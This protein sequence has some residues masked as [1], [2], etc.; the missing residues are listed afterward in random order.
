M[1]IAGKEIYANDDR[2][3]HCM[4]YSK[5]LN[6]HCFQTYTAD[7]KK[8]FTAEQRAK[9]SERAKRLMKEGKIKPWLSRNVTSYAERFF[10]KVLDF[11]N[12]EYQREYS[13]NGYF[14]DFYIEKNNHK[15]DLEID[16]KQHWMDSERAT[17]DL[18][19]DE[20]LKEARFHCLSYSVEQYQ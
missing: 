18:E 14:L 4:E 19:R 7:G 6:I 12:I 5:E 11:N 20:K 9:L 13:S 15:I 17:H 3:N 10:K 8:Y 16:G 1:R 2:C